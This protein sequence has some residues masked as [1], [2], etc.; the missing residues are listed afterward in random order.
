MS[1]TPGYIDVVFPLGALM[2]SVVSEFWLFLKIFLFKNI[3]K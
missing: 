2:A 1:C 3:L